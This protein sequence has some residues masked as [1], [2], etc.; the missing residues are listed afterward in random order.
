MLKIDDKYKEFRLMRIFGV[1]TISNDLISDNQIMIKKK[2][3]R[4]VGY[5]NNFLQC[6]D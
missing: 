5:W 3:Q 2:K 1:P 4:I 6:G